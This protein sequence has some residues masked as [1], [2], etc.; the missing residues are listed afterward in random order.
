M[1]GYAL[2]TGCLV[3]ARVPHIEDVSLKVLSRL[4]VRVERLGGFTCCPEPTLSRL[5]G[6]RLWYALAAR[7]L[8]VA[9]EA[10]LDVLTLCNGCN[11][12]LLKVSEELR[13]DPELRE[14]VNEDLR[15]V[16]RQYGGRVEVRSVLRVLYEEVGVEGLRRAVARPL[17]GLRVAVHHGCHIY[18]ELSL[19]DDVAKPRAFK[20]L[21]SAVGCEVVDYDLEGLCCGAFIR[22]VDEELSMALVREKVEEVKRAGADCIAVTCP[23]CLIQLDASQ[24]VLSRRLGVALRVPVLYLT[25]VVGLSMGMED[26]GLKYHSTP[27]PKKA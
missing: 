4:G 19:Y 18:D 13:R 15:L 10:G 25:Q 16:G 1:R 17:E 24:A 8:A 26:V 5:F 27:V 2:F 20:S 3:Y 12:T 23:S 11:Y 9:E 22:P 7:N 21:L 6:Q 14:R